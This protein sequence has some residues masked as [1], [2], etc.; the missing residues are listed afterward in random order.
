M[1]A[2]ALPA[3]VKLTQCTQVCQLEKRKKERG[4]GW[5][6]EAHAQDET[7]LLNPVSCHW[8]SEHFG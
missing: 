2:L 1:Q 3:S 5:G 8:A 6:P 4:V 7:S